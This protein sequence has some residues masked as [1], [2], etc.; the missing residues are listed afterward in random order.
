MYNIDRLSEILSRVVRGG[1]PSFKTCLAKTCN[2]VLLAWNQASEPMCLFYLDWT[3]YPSTHKNSSLGQA[4]RVLHLL[5]TATGPNN[6][7]DAH[8]STVVTAA[9]G[10]AVEKFSIGVLE[11]LHVTAVVD[12]A[13]SLSNKVR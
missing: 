10:V 13:S 5:H 11:E 12:R 8:V 6:R 1:A 7:T 9:V 4:V 2:K 3:R